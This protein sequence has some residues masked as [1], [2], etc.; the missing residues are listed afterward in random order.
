MNSFITQ[1]KR[2]ILV[3]ITLITTA[4][5]TQPAHADFNV[6]ELGLEAEEGYVL[7]LDEKRFFWF[8]FTQAPNGDQVL[9][10]GQFPHPETVRCANMN[11]L[12]TYDLKAIQ[13]KGSI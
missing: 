8:N 2:L 6:Q 9:C 1:T 13:L 4:C 12:E 10:I 3:A 11:G 5:L 7:Q